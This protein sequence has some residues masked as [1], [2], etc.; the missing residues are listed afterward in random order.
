MNE[1][2]KQLRLDVIA[3]VEKA[4]MAG[5]AQ[6]YK[7]IDTLKMIGEVLLEACRAHAEAL[8]GLIK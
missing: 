4:V 2:A 1:I 7:V 5:K 6:N 3:A 8:K